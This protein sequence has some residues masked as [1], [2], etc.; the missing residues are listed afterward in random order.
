MR[1]NHHPNDLDRPPDAVALTRELLAAKGR[2]L[3]PWGLAG[4]QLALPCH[5]MPSLTHR[6]N[7]KQALAP[8]L[9][10]FSDRLRRNQRVSGHEKSTLT[11]C[12]NFF[13][14]NQ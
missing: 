6:S 9:G 12:K 3:A 7:Q 10:T 1:S 5:A 11:P 13:G 2:A 8:V 4:D 14:A